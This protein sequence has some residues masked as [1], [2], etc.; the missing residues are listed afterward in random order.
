MPE[1]PRWL[2]DTRRIEMMMP[3][4]MLWMVAKHMANTDRTGAVK[5]EGV[6]ADRMLHRARLFDEIAADFAASFNA[7]LADLDDRLRRK[8]AERMSRAIDAALK[9]FDG[10]SGLTVLVVV[11]H[12]TDTL[13][14]EGLWDADDTFLAGYTKLSELVEV[15]ETFELIDAANEAA[16]EQARLALMRLRLAGYYSRPTKH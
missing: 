6:A 12:M 13:I 11:H 16:P 3:S 15:P 7:A 8:M 14:Q 4:R 5:A 1:R 2:T 9:P 10:A